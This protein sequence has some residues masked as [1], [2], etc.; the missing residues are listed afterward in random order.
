MAASGTHAESP[1]TP[2]EVLRRLEESPAEELASTEMFLTVFYAV[3]DAQAGRITFGNAGHA[4]AF[5]VS[6]PTGEATRL[7]AT[8][9]PPR[10]APAPGADATRPW[11]RQDAILFLFT[12]GVA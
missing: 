7:E 11:T 4:H 3:V 8:R 6:T 2:P 1:E 9:P 10:P 12:H 5:L